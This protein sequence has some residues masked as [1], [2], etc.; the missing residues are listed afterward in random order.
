M[1][2]FSSNYDYDIIII[3]GGISGLYCAYK[4]SK[5]QLK[6][7]V[8]EKNDRLGGRINTESRSNLAFDSGARRFHKKHSKFTSL[9]N[10]LGLKDKIIELP[11]NVDYILRGKKSN[12]NYNTTEK[13]D[14]EELLQNAIKNKGKLRK[15]KLMNIT[16]Y[17][18]LMML[19][20]S[21]CVQ[22][23]KD[24]FGYDSEIMELSAYSAIN[25]YKGDLF[26]ENKYYTLNGG[27]S[28][29][30]DR[31]EEELKLM[32]NVVLKKGIDISELHEKYIITG[33]KDKFN[34]KH[35]ILT[36][37]ANKLKHLSYFNDKLSF[38]SV[39][40]VKLLRIY[41][42]YP[43]TNLWFRNIKTT[44]TD[45][46]IRNIIPIDYDKGLIMISYTDGI[47]SRMLES[48]NQISK[49]LLVKILHKEIYH[50]FGI[51]PPKPRMISTHF[52]ENGI[53]LWKPGYDMDDEY[54]KMIKPN[55]SEEIY[56]CGE[57]F[58]KKQG[59][60]EGALETCFDVIQSLPL[61]DFKVQVKKETIKDIH[62]EGVEEDG[63]DSD[64]E[65]V[66]DKYYSIE[67][68]LLQKKWIILDH[69]GKKGIYDLKNWVKIHPGGSII[70]KGIDS[71]G[72]YDP[73]LRKTYFKSP[74]DVWKTFHTDDILNKYIIQK[75]EYISKIGYLKE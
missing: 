37:P 46:Y 17:Q 66:E 24:T 26:G 54:N 3:G 18:Y 32:E 20:D 39:K 61:G 70:S 49:S 29:I 38:D 62:T 31:L 14:T 42:Q 19:Y 58:S 50:L 53:H 75:N 59:W 30:I 22:F 73:E 56:L 67:E 63:E 16:F 11:D 4:L 9:I 13:L 45:N 25:M 12:Y 27:L 72:Y 33:D 48:Y 21:E 40:P 52:W 60:I 44:I 41:I 8:L 55:K 7:L 23:I 1:N 65:D 2:I 51:E 10:E 68:V 57:S 6:I 43:T 71:N 35:V 15:G 36:I 74:Y 28:Q 5:T 47:Y 69:D 64:N 34:Y